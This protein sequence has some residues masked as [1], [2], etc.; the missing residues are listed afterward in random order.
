MQANRIHVWKSNTEN[1]STKFNV[2][3]QNFE[4]VRKN[5]DQQN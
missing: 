2:V 3:R 4:N 5:D 1:L